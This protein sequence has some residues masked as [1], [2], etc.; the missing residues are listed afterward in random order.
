MAFPSDTKE[1][2][3]RE[4]LQRAVQ[5]KRLALKRERILREIRAYESHMVDRIIE[6]ARG[7][8]LSESE[9]VVEEKSATE[10]TDTRSALILAAHIRNIRKGTKLIV[11]NLMNVNALDTDTIIVV[12]SASEPVDAASHGFGGSSDHWSLWRATR[13]T[14][15]LRWA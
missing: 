3:R 10:G 12:Y 8:T 15:T 6:E 14:L 13:F 5:Q 1:N 4:M 9:F 2:L 7:V 11:N